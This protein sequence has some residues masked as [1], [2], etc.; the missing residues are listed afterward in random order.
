MA[1]RG[2]PVLVAPWI[3][4]ACR[5]RWPEDPGGLQARD[6]AVAPRSIRNRLALRGAIRC[7]IFLVCSWP[8]RAKHP[9]RRAGSAMFIMCLAQVQFYYPCGIAGPWRAAG[10]VGAGHRAC[11][12]DSSVP[13]RVPDMPALGAG[14]ASYRIAF[15][16]L[17]RQ[18][19]QAGREEQIEA[20]NKIEAVSPNDMQPFILKCLLRETRETGGGSRETPGTGGRCNER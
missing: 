18:I 12:G 8:A 19:G 3:A 9:P 11:P 13:S 15:L 6:G 1:L 5:A 20:I 10:M 2:I 7:T 14:D 16:A 17:P 4:A